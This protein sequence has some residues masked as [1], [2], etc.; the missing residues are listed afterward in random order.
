MVHNALAITWGVHQAA[1]VRS[2]GQPVKGQL[3]QRR[4]RGAHRGQVRGEAATNGPAKEGKPQRETA[5]LGS[6]LKIGNPRKN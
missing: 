5:N 6:Q 2:D 4:W 1:G 3:L